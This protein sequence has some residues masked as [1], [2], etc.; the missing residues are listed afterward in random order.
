M[1]RQIT[2]HAGDLL[3]ALAAIV[4]DAAAHWQAYWTFDAVPAHKEFGRV[5]KSHSWWYVLTREAYF[6]GAVISLG[7]FFEKNHHTVNI[8]I[9]ID[10]LDAGEWSPELAEIS[11]DLDELKGTIKDIAII[12][13]NFY[14]HRNRELTQKEIFS[15]TSLR[16]DDIPATIRRMERILNRVISEL[17]GSEVNVKSVS[18]HTEQ[19]IRNLLSKL[20]DQK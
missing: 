17:G 9:F 1:K 19:E 10:Q 11:H 5:F 12:R 8:W 4:H 6:L 7:K 3:E 16:Y 15:K 2:K 20:K 14:A 13:S 18:E